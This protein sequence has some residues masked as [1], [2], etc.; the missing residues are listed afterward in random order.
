MGGSRAA[1]VGS[2]GWAV[3]VAAGSCKQQETLHWS[4]FGGMRRPLLSPLPTS[5]HSIRPQ[6]CSS[7]FCLAAG[8]AASPAVG[9]R[10]ARR[11]APAGPSRTPARC[12]A[13]RRAPATRTR[14]GAPSGGSPRPVVKAPWHWRPQ[15]Y[16]PDVPE[17]GD[18]GKFQELQR[19]AQRLITGQA[20]AP[21][22]DAG[23]LEPL[24]GGKG[25]R[26]T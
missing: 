26:G 9:D 1:A 22:W 5:I 10:G 13:C 2:H 15:V 11:A 24:G 21:A 14:S 25:G 20:P 8:R 23:S 3:E 4:P 6:V 17:T 7:A 18:I 16:H 19:A 12:W